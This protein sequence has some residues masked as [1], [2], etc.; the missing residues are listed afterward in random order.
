MGECG[1]NGNL[2]IAFLPASLAWGSPS[3]ALPETHSN[4]N[5]SVGILFP[6]SGHATLIRHTQPPHTLPQN[7][8]TAI[9]PVPVGIQHFFPISILQPLLT[10]VCIS[11]L[12]PPEPS[13]LA[14]PS[15]KVF[16]KSPKSQMTYPIP[17]LAPISLTGTFYLTSRGG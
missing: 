10:P 15:R 7:P 14:T 9:F 13:T 16:C 3:T 1:G 6:S 17:D 12:G 5:P 2:K 8:S 4:Y 11:N